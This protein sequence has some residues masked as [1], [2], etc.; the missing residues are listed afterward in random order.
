MNQRNLFGEESFNA[1][2][3]SFLFR[4]RLIQG[5]WPIHQT[6]ATVIKIQNK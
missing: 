2:L 3:I 1:L 4:S 5:S 6:C